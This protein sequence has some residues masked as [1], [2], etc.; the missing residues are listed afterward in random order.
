MRGYY[1]FLIIVVI[2]FSIYSCTSKSEKAL[3]DSF[4][5]PP[6]E[7]RMNQNTHEFPLQPDLQDSLINRTLENGWGGFTINT[8]YSEYLTEKGLQSTLVFCQKAKAKEMDL[9]LYDEHGYPSGN[10]GDLVIKE[11]PEWEEHM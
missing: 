4:A 7:F 8:P 1:K 5:N 6:L 10:A 11:N 3:R 2:G 9:W